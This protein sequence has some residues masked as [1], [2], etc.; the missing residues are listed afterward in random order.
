MNRTFV[1]ADPDVKIPRNELGQSATK[2]R[3]ETVARLEEKARGSRG[4]KNR[5][6]IRA[7]IACASLA[8]VLLLAS[9]GDAAK[10]PTSPPP[11]LGLATAAVA[12]TTAPTASTPA[13]AASECTN[14]TAT[15]RQVIERYF[16]L[17]T[18]NSTQA[19]TDCFAKVWRDKTA[20]FADGVAVWSNAGPA[21]SVSVTFIDTVNGCDRFSVG[22]QLSN[23][24]NSGYRV[25]PFFSVGADGGRMR[26]YETSTALTNAAATTLRCP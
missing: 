21:T 1:P 17:S 15:S 6:L 26:I 7:R 3:A 4:R 12:S 22:A 9:C 5:E 25:P 13:V 11:I 23:A 8:V 14:A 10:A 2:T 24:L 20:S 18:S 16:A 19:V